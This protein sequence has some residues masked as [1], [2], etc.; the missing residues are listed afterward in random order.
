LKPSAE[1]CHKKYMKNPWTPWILRKKFEIISILG[2][3]KLQPHLRFFIIS[4]GSENWKIYP[5]KF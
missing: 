2:I 1:G 5:N 4:L 3:P